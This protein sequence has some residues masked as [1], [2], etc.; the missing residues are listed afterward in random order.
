MILG[1]GVD[2]CKIARIQRLIDKSEYARTRFLTGTFHESEVA[3]FNAKE[4]DH[5]KV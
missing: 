2:I 1:I 4:V 5:V 3:E